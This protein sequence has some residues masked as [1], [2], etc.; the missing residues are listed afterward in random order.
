[1]NHLRLN[2]DHG[3]L[4][5]ATRQATLDGKQ[6][7]AEGGRMACDWVPYLGCRR[8]VMVMVGVVRV[9]VGSWRW[10]LWR[11]QGQEGKA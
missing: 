9:R 11:R 6:R 1:M 3:S 2:T 10:V 5:N 8:Q 4:D 7:G